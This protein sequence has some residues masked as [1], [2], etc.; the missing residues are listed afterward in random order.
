MFIRWRRSK[1][2]GNTAQAAVRQQEGDGREQESVSPP[3]YEIVAHLITD[4][5]CVREIN[6][7]C[8]RCVFPGDAE[9]IAKKGQ[10]FVVADGMGGHTAGELASRLAVDEICRSYY[11][12]P[13]DPHRSLKRAFADANEKI[14]V[15]ASEQT[16]L[17]GMGTTCTALVVA[18]GKAFAAHVGDSRLY[19]VRDGE[20]YL[21]TVDHSAVME[22]VKQG[23][24]TLEE[25]RHHP[26]KNVILR[27][28]GVHEAVE[29][30]S[31]DAPFTI[32]TGDQF[33]LC[34]DG[35]YDLVSDEEMRDAVLASD[36]ER[37]CAELVELA[38]QRGGHDNIT[39]GVVSVAAVDHTAR[40]VPAWVRDTREV[41][42]AS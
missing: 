39:V 11:S 20:M 41:E 14:F 26:D 12:L 24:L 5:G 1:P 32:R 38:K 22:L 30:S 40:G 8:G 21:M 33:L 31:W 34:S 13:D 10:L 16:E 4:R 9:T 25:A 28:L 2:S 3:G 42:I 29:V 15:T 18:S 6:E 19:L 17:Q 36:A 35:L 23:L 7:D 27:A 37:A